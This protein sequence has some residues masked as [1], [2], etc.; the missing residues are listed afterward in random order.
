MVAILEIGAAERLTAADTEPGRNIGVIW[1][2]G[3]RKIV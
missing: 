3:F 1:G 2:V